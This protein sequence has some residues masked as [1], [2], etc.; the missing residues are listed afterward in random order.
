MLRRRANDDVEDRLRRLERR[1]ED[2][3]D[4]VAATSSPDRLDDVVHRLEELSLTA[5][6]ADALL[7]VR[8]DVARLAAEVSAV[9]AQLQQDI[10]TIA[11]AVV[12]LAD[13]RLPRRAAG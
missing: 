6:T 12:D 3:E 1:L 13:P 11:A 10:D 2:V 7:R 8:T 9:R 5:T 4:V